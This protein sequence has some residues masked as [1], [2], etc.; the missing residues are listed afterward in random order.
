MTRLLG[1]NLLNRPL[2]R[3]THERFVIEQSVMSPGA[4]A[5]RLAKHPQPLPDRSDRSFRFVWSN[6]HNPTDKSEERVLAA[7]G[8]SG[9][10]P[11]PG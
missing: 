11:A 5:A 8:E 3:I 1:S 7:R 4:D 9:F 2:G 10:V 6:R